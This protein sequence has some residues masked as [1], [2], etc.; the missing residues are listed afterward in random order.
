MPTFDGLGA[1]RDLLVRLTNMGIREIVFK[2]NGEYKNQRQKFNASTDIVKL[3]FSTKEYVSRTDSKNDLQKCMSISEMKI[4]YNDVQSGDFV[5]TRDML[6]FISELSS[7]YK[8]ELSQFVFFAEI[9][10]QRKHW[11]RN[12]IRK[13]LCYLHMNGDIS[14]GPNFEII[15]NIGK[16]GT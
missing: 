7:K 10:K 12:A 3:L 5:D 6:D 4:S 14:I 16:V 9:N 11:R 1:S 2:F 13:S 15:L 8:G